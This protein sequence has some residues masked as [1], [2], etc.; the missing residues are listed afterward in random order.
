MGLPVEEVTIAEVLKQRGYHNVHIGKWHLG[1]AR[2]FHPIDQGFDESLLM[3][4]LLHL[5]EGDPDVVN[6]KLDFD[7]ID[8]RFGKSPIFRPPIMPGRN[9]PPVAIC[10]I[11]GPTRR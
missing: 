1:G 7:L 4:S 5:P 3:E 9:L 2:P 8:K 11:T 10:R 6:A